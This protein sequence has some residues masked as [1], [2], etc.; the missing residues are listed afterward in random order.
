M[1]ARRA[2]TLVGSCGRPRR[3]PDYWTVAEAPQ[4]P[5]LLCL[6]GFLRAPAPAAPQQ[7][8]IAAH[9]PHGVGAGRAAA[10]LGKRGRLKARCAPE[11]AQWRR[12]RRFCR[13]WRLARVH[14][15]LHYLGMDLRRHE[16]CAAR[17]RGA[18]WP[19]WGRASALPLRHRRAAATASITPGGL[20]TRTSACSTSAGPYYCSRTAQRGR[21]ARGSLGWEAWPSFVVHCCSNDADA[22][23]PPPLSRLATCERTPAPAL[24][25]QGPKTA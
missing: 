22:S 18:R 1:G 10:S 4:L 3:S 20:P 9:E 12:R 7:G 6:A 21:C 25:R 24:P 8:P 17:A 16:S 2:S 13:A 11:P 23:P 5:S 14:Q 19:P 15:R